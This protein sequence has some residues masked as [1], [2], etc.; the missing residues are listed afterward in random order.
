MIIARYRNQLLW[1]RH[2][3]RATWEIPGGHIESGESALD[4]AHRE[5]REETGATE[6]CITPLCW[7][8]AYRDNS[9]PHSTGLLCIA[10]VHSLSGKL[11]CEIAEIRPLSAPPDDLTY[12]EIQPMLLA[13]AKAR[14]AI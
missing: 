8:S 9:E 13:E 11:Q 4:A 14:G 6:F 5:L 2:R 10:D 7:Y 1:C 12:P 3:E